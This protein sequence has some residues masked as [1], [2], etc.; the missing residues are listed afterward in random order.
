MKALGAARQ[1][2]KLQKISKIPK[3][4][5]FFIAINFKG[6]GVMKKNKTEIGKNEDD[7]EEPKDGIFFRCPIQIFFGLKL[8][9][10]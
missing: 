4:P 9:F 6:D 10:R 5:T 1:K 7:Y 3:V 2:W 8:M